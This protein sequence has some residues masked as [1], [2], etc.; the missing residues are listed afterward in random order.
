MD[1]IN[2]S[3][4]RFLLLLCT[5]RVHITYKCSNKFRIAQMTYLIIIIQLIII[6]IIIGLWRYRNRKIKSKLFTY[7]VM[8][9]KFCKPWNCL[10]I[11]FPRHSLSLSP[12]LS[13]LICY[14]HWWFSPCIAT[15]MIIATIMAMRIDTVN[16]RFHNWHFDGI[17]HLLVNGYEFFHMIRHMLFHGVWHFFD[18][19]I[20]HNFLNRNGD[21]LDDGYSVGFRDR[22]VYR[23]RLRLW[24]Q[25]LMRYWYVHRTL[26]W[27]EKKEEKKHYFVVWCRRWKKIDFGSFSLTRATILLGEKFIGE[28]GLWED[29]K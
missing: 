27:E 23:I 8:K 9:N 7:K 29:S 2:R 15:T 26:N 16:N 4:L 13:L 18:H 25:N 11:F 12:S 1:L 21:F 22:Y 17:R 3:V 24:Y 6:I 14:S 20:R 28:C 10:M 5:S 19:R